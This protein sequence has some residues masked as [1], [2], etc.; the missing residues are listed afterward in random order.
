MTS[1]TCTTMQGYSLFVLPDEILYEIACLLTS[2]RDRL[3]LAMTCRALYRLVTSFDGR[4]SLVNPLEPFTRRHPA[5]NAIESACIRGEVSRMHYFLQDTRV[6]QDQAS[7]PVLFSKAASHGQWQVLDTLLAHW[8]SL[9]QPAG[10]KNQAIRQASQNGYTATVS[11]LLTLPEV[12]PSD[13]GYYA[14]KV[15]CFKGYT[16]VVAALLSHPRGA[17]RLGHDDVEASKCLKWAIDGEDVAVIRQLLDYFLTQYSEANNENVEVQPGAAGTRVG[18]VGLPTLGCDELCVLAAS[19]GLT[20]V[21]ETLLAHDAFRPSSLGLSQSIVLASKGGYTDVLTCILQYCPWAD[22]ACQDNEP[23]IVA[24]SHGETAMVKMLLEDPRVNANARESQALRLA[25][26]NGH[27]N[28]AKLL[29]ED[30]RVNPSSWDWEALRWLDEQ[31][32]GRGSRQAKF[33]VAKLTEIRS[34]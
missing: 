25:C 28:T 20:P 26:R 6:A 32:D 19:R 34:V 13:L 9:C 12:D 21:V 22:P 8:G 24:A 14:L 10:K 29:L 11:Y 23:L 1:I 31:A 30:G 7:A 27:M 15:A 33:L 4:L 17:P 16:G 3:S 2:N 5:K 18:E